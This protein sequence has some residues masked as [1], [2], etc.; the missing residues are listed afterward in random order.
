MPQF[1]P[2]QKLDRRGF[3]KTAVLLRKRDFQN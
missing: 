3:L 1:D 2:T